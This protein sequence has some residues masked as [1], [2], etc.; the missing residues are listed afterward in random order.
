[1]N[2][3]KKEIRELNK[4]TAIHIARQILRL[5]RDLPRLVAELKRLSK[6][7]ALKIEF[8]ADYILVDGV[9]VEAEQR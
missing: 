1:M 7:S 3:L 8:H 6:N 9:K 2:D 5:N 4:Q